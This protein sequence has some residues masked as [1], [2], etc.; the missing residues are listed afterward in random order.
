MIAKG[1]QIIAVANDTRWL[2]EGAKAAR[3]VIDGGGEGGATGPA[4]VY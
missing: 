3:R 1:W 2:S 4:G